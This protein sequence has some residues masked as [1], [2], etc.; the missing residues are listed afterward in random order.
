M[1][2]HAFFYRE[3]F[4]SLLWLFNPHWLE[5]LKDVVQDLKTIGADLHAKK[6]DRDK[7]Y[8]HIPDIIDEMANL[9]RFHSKYHKQSFGKVHVGASGSQIELLG[10]KCPGRLKQISGDVLVY[11]FNDHIKNGDYKIA[12]T[13]VD[14]KAILSIFYHHRVFWAGLVGSVFFRA[15]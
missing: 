9:C 11:S 4:Q 3:L 5:T 6:L 1:N 2:S 7:A 10:D 14:V 15:K 12:F 13:E 8:N